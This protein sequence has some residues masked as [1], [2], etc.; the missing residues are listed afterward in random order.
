M[1]SGPAAF[2]APAGA[3]AGA[4][5]GANAPP[6]AAQGRGQTQAPV[7]PPPP[8]PQQ[9]QTQAQQ[10]SVP[11]QRRTVD[12]TVPVL[13][14]LEAKSRQAEPLNG[15]VLSEPTVLPTRASLVDLR[16]PAGSTGELASGAATKF[17]HVSTN[18]YRSPLHASVFT[19][20]GKRLLTGSAS[21]QFTVWNAY[22]FKFENYLPAHETGIRCFAW[23]HS[24][25]WLLSGDDAGQVKV[26][27]SVVNN[28]KA[29]NAHRER[30]CSM[31]FAPTDLKFATCSTDT[32][33]KVWDFARVQAEV[34]MLGHGG[35]VF[36]TD[37]HPTH[38]LIATGSRD[39]LA[40]LWDARA[41]HGG[42]NGSASSGNTAAASLHGHKGPVNAV[43]WSS[44][45]NW[46]LTCSSDNSMK[47]FDLRTLKCLSTLSGH[48]AN[49][50]CA[51][52]HPHMEEVVASGSQDGSLGHWIVGWEHPVYFINKAHDQPVEDIS[53]HPVGHI[54][55]TGALDCCSKFW[56]RP[57]PG[58]V[59]KDLL[60]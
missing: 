50:L 44:N 28:V 48:K 3:A 17:V 2:A 33:V 19:P 60:S 41:K 35:D 22:D 21:G 10:R 51:E 18:K 32:T 52:W 30:V 55:A 4:A 12:P 39:W 56:V 8:P 11:L 37:W 7:P 29:F 15:P 57:R 1:A 49:V 58:E 43:R 5:A 24:E 20:D 36:T 9:A 14:E 34:S 53:W 40:K 25:V 45:G 46:L 23:A 54:L 31:S 16:S 26:W 13:N 27:K 59:P 42:G 38:S 47:V 6:Y